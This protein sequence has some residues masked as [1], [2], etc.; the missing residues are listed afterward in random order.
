MKHV[1][2]S[3]E[4]MDKHNKDMKLGASGYRRVHNRRG[5]IQVGNKRR[6]VTMDD[7][8]DPSAYDY[9]TLYGD[10]K[11]VQFSYGGLSI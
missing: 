1:G 9:E 3:D 11:I 2:R 10:P 6:E 5:T 8:F 7:G 4:K